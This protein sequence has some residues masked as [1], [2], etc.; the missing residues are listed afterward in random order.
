MHVPFL[1]N[2]YIDLKANEFLVRYGE[3]NSLPIEI[4]IIIQDKLRIEIVPVTNLLKD[5]N[6]DGFSLADGSGIYIDEFIYMHRENRARFTMAHEIGHIEL[7]NDHLNQVAAEHGINDI[8]SWIEF[9]ICMGGKARSWFEYQGNAFG[10]MLLV[11]TSHL[12]SHFT[13]VIPSFSEQIEEAKANGFERCEYLDFIVDGVARKL[14]PTFK[15]STFVVKRRIIN[16]ELV[17]R[18]G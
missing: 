2:S 1:H 13:R 14:A 11:P 17:N 8:N 4:E 5:F 6:I 3:Q 15:V 9:L 10:G 16:S 7:H 18:I 12:E